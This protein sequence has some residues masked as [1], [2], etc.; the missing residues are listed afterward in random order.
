MPPGLETPALDLPPVSLAR[1]FKR[2][3]AI[4]ESL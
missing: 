2:T 1:I 3:P 4:N